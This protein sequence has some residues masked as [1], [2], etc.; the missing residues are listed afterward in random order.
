M[1]SLEQEF[2]DIFNDHLYLDNGHDKAIEETNKL[3][4]KKGFFNQLSKESQSIALDFAK[5]VR[6]EGYIYAGE[7]DYMYPDAN[8]LV[9]GKHL[10]NQFIE[11]Y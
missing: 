5:Y 11:K 8:G 10:F 3:I 6:T 2:E 9:S 4:D 7:G 1:N